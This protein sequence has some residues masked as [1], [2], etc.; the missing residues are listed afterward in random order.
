MIDSGPMAHLTTINPDGSPQVTV[1]WVGSDGGDIVSGHMSHKRLVQNIERDPRVVLSFDAPREPGAVLNPYATVR[2]HGDRQYRTDPGSLES[3]QPA[4]EDLHRPETRSSLRLEVQ[5]MSRVTGSSGRS[6]SAFGDDIVQVIGGTPY[7]G[8]QKAR[9]SVYAARIQQSVLLMGAAMTDPSSTVNQVLD[10]WTV[11]PAAE[12]RARQERTRAAAEA[13]GLDAVVVYT[14]GGGFMDM[15]ADVLWLS[16]HY[17]QQPYMGDEAGVGTARSHGVV[18]VP[19]D[20]PLTVV[21][22]VPWW[23]RDFVVAD[24]VRPSIDVTGTTAAVLREQGLTGKRIG[25]AGASY[26]TAAAWL[27]LQE[28]MPD[29]TLVRADTLVDQLRVIKSPAEQQLIRRACAIG[30]LT[31]E[32]LIDAVVEGATEAEAVGEA[33]RVLLRGGGVLYDAACGSGPHAHTYTSGRLPSADPVRRFERGDMFHV[34]CYGSVGGYFFDFAR[35][36]VVGDDPTPEQLKLLEAPIGIV[37]QI[38]AVHQ[39][40]DDQR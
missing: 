14:R 40:G 15:S 25:V 28:A 17:S 32:T 7:S 4:R 8:A 29:A 11:I 19:V 16:G 2:A 13:A 33:S 35:S 36:R 27:G 1:I 34:D 6:R 30:N 3:A 38:C 18:I 9:S 10:P 23:R 31:L 22:D 12:F 5:A 24:A 37:E 39:A 26:M 21:V 20:A